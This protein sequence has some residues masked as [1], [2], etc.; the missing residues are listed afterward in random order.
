[1][2]MKHD[3][4]FTK[5]VGTG[6]DFIVIDNKAGEL[7]VRELDYGQIARDLCRRRV[8]VGADGLLVLERSD[9]ADFK[10]RIINPDGSE[11]DMC[12][13]GLRCSAYYACRAGWGDELDVETR[14]GILST[15][16]SGR[17]V[18]IKMGDPKDVRMGIKLGVGKNMMIL[19]SLNTGVPHVVHLVEDVEGY[20]VTGAGRAIRTHSF[21]EPDGTNVNFVGDVAGDSA[22]IRTY[23]RGVED[24]T[25]ACGTGTVAS[26]VVL[27]LLGYVKSPVEMLTQS[28]EKLRVHFKI[29]A[30]KVSN[31]RLEG[32]ARIV[33]EGKA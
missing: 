30:D 2:S 12:G 18:S 10:M 19:H 3:I 24:E 23:E 21:F 31:V 15:K 11:V 22:R 4:C 25:L 29:S 27:G 8:S 6:N 9:K 14:A 20:D 33:Y 26:A 1:M 13:N 5:V 28:G 7:D 32:E 17:E 16:T